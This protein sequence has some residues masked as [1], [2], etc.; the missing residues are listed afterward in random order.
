MLLII[1]SFIKYLTRK[2]FARL[3]AMALLIC[4][5]MKNLRNIKDVCE[6]IHYKY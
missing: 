6:N 3:R 4:K 5:Y 2:D 1:K